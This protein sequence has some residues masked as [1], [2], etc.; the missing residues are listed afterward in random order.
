MIAA[1]SACSTPFGSSFEPPE[2]SVGSIE[3]IRPGLFSQQLSVAVLVQNNMPYPL[4][5][6]TVDL[7][8]DV[9]GNRLGAGAALRSIEVAANSQVTA[10]VAVTVKTQDIFDLITEMSRRPRLGYEITGHVRV[11]GG[12]GTESW[13]EVVPFEDE[14]DLE[15]QI[16]AVPFGLS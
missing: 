13:D 15:L 10:P 3:M 12:D 4:T 16:P 7:E 5:I 11:T 6:E 8:L 1:L 2:V 9:N 14:E